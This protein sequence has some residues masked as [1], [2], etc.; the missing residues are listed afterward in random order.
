MVHVTEAHISY[1]GAT[2]RLAAGSFV[3]AGGSCAAEVDSKRLPGNGHFAC[4]RYKGRAQT[5]RP[6]QDAKWTYGASAVEGHNT[7]SP[8]AAF[9]LAW[10]EAIKDN[11]P[12]DGGIDAAVVTT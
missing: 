1:T 4:M 11:S 9:W 2:L 6:C 3:P 5:G 8:A 10:G 7:K 12:T